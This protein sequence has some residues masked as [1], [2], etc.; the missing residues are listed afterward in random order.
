M[1]FMPTVKESA[2]DVEQWFRNQAANLWP[3]ALGSL[4]FRRNP[5]IREHCEA[6]QRGDKHPSHVLYGRMKGRRFTIY[7]PDELVPDVQRSLD[8]GRQL[9]EL[10]YQMAMRY[11]KALKHERTA[12]S[13]RV[14]E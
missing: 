2:A 4:S 1:Y 5:C 7:I 8:N 9:Q 13:Q 12:K 11:T 3:A 14:K 6:C 10:L